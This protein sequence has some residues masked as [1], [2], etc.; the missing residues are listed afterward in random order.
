[1]PEIS[2]PY[3]NDSDRYEAIVREWTRKYAM[4]EYMIF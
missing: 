1:M 4:G 2:Y 3:E